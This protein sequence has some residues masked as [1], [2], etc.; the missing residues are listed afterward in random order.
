M[1]P[2]SLN[3]RENGKLTERLIFPWAMAD[4]GGMQIP[5]QLL[6]KTLTQSNSE[7]IQRSVQNLE[8]TFVDGMT[9]LSRKRTKKIAVIK[10]Q[11]ELADRYLADFLSTLKDY[12]LI[13]PFTLDS[14]DTTP[15][16][17]LDVLNTYDLIIDAKPTKAFT[18]EKNY[19]L[20]QYLMNGGKAIW[21]IEH[22]VAE[23]DSLYKASKKTVAF[24][25][26]LNLYS[27]FFRYGVRI[28]PQLVNDLYS[29]PI[30]LASGSGNSSQLSRFPWFYDPLGEP[31][32]EHPITENLSPVKFEF[33]NP[34]DTLESHLNK[35]ILLE[36]SNLSRVIGTPAEVS[37]DEITKEPDP[38]LYTTGHFPLAVL[39]EGEF[40]SAF[41]SKLKP[42]TLQSPKDRS[43]QTQQVF[44]SD[45]DLIK[46]Q[47]EDGKPLELGF[48][49]FTGL[50]YGN[51]TFL[52]NM[53]NYLLGDESLVKT[54]SKSISLDEM[55]LEK[56]KST[57]LKWQLFNVIVPIAS[58]ISFGLIVVYW[59]KRKYKSH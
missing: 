45:G 6:Q 8:Y 48:D 10:G 33:A 52:L 53:V 49:R 50:T 13:A 43:P 58:I 4:Y 22:V 29:A 59:R 3:I 12:Y 54:R 37:L 42:L 31:V 7:M 46:N 5:I 23:K 16:K 36:S 20:D 28:N 44:I 30:V 15:Q 51:K 55:D 38:R 57:K 41:K 18:D 40:N 47:L 11:G 25:I 56:L 1:S 32:E 39:V 24:P 19:V 2:E 27:L 9:K 35:T 17:T 21:L 26:D 34:I 14:V